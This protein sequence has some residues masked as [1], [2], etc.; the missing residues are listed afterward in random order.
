MSSQIVTDWSAQGGNYRANFVNG[1]GEFTGQVDVVEEVVTNYLEHLELVK[2]EKLLHPLGDNAPGFPEIAESPRSNISLAHLKTNIQALSDIY[3][4]KDGHGF[5][6]ILNN[7]LEQT[8]IATEMNEALTRAQT[9][10]NSVSNDFEQAINNEAD[11][12]ALNEVIN[13]LRDFRT[14]LT[15]DFCSSN[16]FKHWL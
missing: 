7:H 9:A 15:A 5:D 8:A 6:D 12:E 11:R 3:T 2:D 4:A 10:I 13:A 14:V 1:T 16:G